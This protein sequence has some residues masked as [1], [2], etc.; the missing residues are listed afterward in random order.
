MNDDCVEVEDDGDWGPM[1]NNLTPT[2]GGGGKREEQQI[3]TIN[4]NNRKDNII[5]LLIRLK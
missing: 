2:I 1:R 5:L 4:I 3:Q